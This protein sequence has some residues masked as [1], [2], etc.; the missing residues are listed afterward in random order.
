MTANRDQSKIYG[1]SDPTL[2]YTVTPGSG[3]IGSALVGTD[4]LGG[5]LSYTGTSVGSYLLNQGTLGNANYAITYGATPVYFG[6]TARPITVTADDAT[7]KL[8]TANPIFT[9]TY[10]GL[11]TGDTTESLGTLEFSTTP[12]IISRVGTYMIT[13]SALSSINYTINYV[14]GILTV[15]SSAD[16]YYNGAVITADQ[17]TSNGI[18]GLRKYTNLQKA[19]LGTVGGSSSG[20]WSDLNLTIVG[21]GVNVQ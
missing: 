12:K 16:A 1:E 18:S 3:T 19:Y 21:N 14:A 20:N 5:S 13:P 9:A 6:I 8:G 17:T 11:A 10:R 4:T 2:A 15:K 7:K